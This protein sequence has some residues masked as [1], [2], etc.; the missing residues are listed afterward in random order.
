MLWWSLQQLKSKNPE[1]RI[2]AIEK[3]REAEDERII[4]ALYLSATK[5]VDSGVR[6]CAVRKIEETRCEAAQEAL[7]Q[8]LKDKEM[9]IQEAAANALMIFADRKMIP[10][11]TKLIKARQSSVRWVAAKILESLDWSPKNEQEHAYLLV[12]TNQLDRAIDM[13]EQAVAALALM[14]NDDFYY[15]RQASVE[16]LGKIGGQKVMQLLVSQPLKD[17]DSHVK[18]SAIETLGRIGDNSVVDPIIVTLRD[19]DNRVREAA[20]E[21]LSHIGDIRAVAPL[22]GQL[23]DP[24]WDVRKAC[25]AALALIGRDKNA[26]VT[27]PLVEALKDRDPDVRQS[28]AAALGEV[29]DSAGITPLI[30]AL[31]DPH[32]P[33]RQAAAA[34]LKRVEYDWEL[35]QGALDALPELQK[36]LNHKDYW[37][38]QCAADTIEAI[39]EARQKI[40]PEEF[41]SGPVEN[42]GERVL[43]ALSDLLE[44]ED[45]DFRLAAAQALG[46]VGDLPA[47]DLLGTALMDSDSWVRLSAAESLDG[48]NWSPKDRTLQA[49][50]LVILNN[51]D[52]AAAMGADAIDALEAARHEHNISSRVAATEALARMQE[53]RAFDALGLFLEDESE[54]VRKSATEALIGAGKEPKDPAHRAL[55]ALELDDWARL[56]MLG[57]FA[58]PGLINVMKNRF[59]NANRYQHA[60][61]T[62]LQM[63]L[64]ASE[65]ASLLREYL[66]DPEVAEVILERLYNMVHS[67]SSRFPVNELNRLVKIN[68][69]EQ[70]EYEFDMEYGGYIQ[71]GMKTI[72]CSPLKELCQTALQKRASI[73]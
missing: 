31:K 30:L 2:H 57:K 65:C 17:K 1:V 44:D 6:L 12:A 9:E 59:E 14:L 19:P 34:A 40:N 50:Q 35:T 10:S 20:A 16:A 33:V 54:N 22:A 69:V 8:C 66:N 37:V 3:I 55:M 4:E 18:V 43:E 15:K 32:N 45:R 25:V 7:L 60:R 24:S 64:H 29:K 38:R 67:D 62:F 28:A 72:D 51:W 58:I 5:D 36:D 56:S 46:R 68:Q 73:A 13:G 70:Y 21:A 27:E 39:E 42:P 61:D 23:K 11:L 26:R 49:R 53:A 47:T 52:A 41:E 48:L 71:S 63:R